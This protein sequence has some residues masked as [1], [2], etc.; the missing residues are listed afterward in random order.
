MT[1]RDGLF[2]VGA[3]GAGQTSPTEARLAAAGLLAPGAGGID[4]RPGALYG[5]GNPLGVTGTGSMTYS[6]AAGH[7]AASRG[8]SLG[9]YLACN[10]AAATVSTGA[11]PG[12]GSRYDLIWI[13]Q[14][15]AEQGDADSVAVIGVTQG[16][17]SGSP[18]K[19]YGSVPA[20]AL[21]LAE[22]L[23]A[24]GATSTNDVAHVTI[25]QVAAWTA[26]RG[27]LVPVR[28]QTERDALTLFESLTVW[29]LDVHALE[30][31][32]GTAWVRYSPTWTSYS[33]TWA[34]SGTAPSLGNGTLTG[35]YQ[36][37]GKTVHFSIKLVAGNT[38]TFGTGSYSLTLPVAPANKGRTAVTATLSDIS[39]GNVYV[40]ALYFL[41]TTSGSLVTIG[42]SGL[43]APVTNTAPFT[44]ANTDEIVVSGTYEAA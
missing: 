13:R 16:T 30:T 12:S 40:A 21:V 24:S 17:S 4:F 10:D 3:A 34:S 38:T 28:S 29:R 22:S 2:V 36:Q 41:S 20:G 14:P 15:D 5:P 32:T 6:V 18:T 8:T 42:T 11:A 35:A 27:A 37:L 26:A 31:Y 19:P 39:A 7:F 33:P 43:V 25:T 9:V 23:V 44:W 1:A